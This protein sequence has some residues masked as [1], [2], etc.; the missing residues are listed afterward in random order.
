MRPQS[1]SL[2][3]RRPEHVRAVGVDGERSRVSNASQNECRNSEFYKIKQM[4]SN[5][6]IKGVYNQRTA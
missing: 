6:N 4:R 2:Y 3:R 1:V 5:V